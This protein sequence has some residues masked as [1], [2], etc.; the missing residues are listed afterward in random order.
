MVSGH[1][2]KS[3]LNSIHHVVQNTMNLHSKE[4]ILFSLRDFF[5]Q[6]TFY[7]YVVDSYGY[8]KVVDVTDLPLDAGINDD[9]TTRLCIQ[10]SF[11]MESSFYPALVVR[12]GSFNSVPISFN[13]E[14]SGVQWDDMIFE[15][16]YG[17]IS[18]FKTPVHFI[19]AGAWE[20]SINIDI[21]ARDMRSRDDLTDLVAVRFVDIAFN[22][23]V[24]EG[25]IVLNVSTSGP[26]ESDDRNHKVFK[27]TVTLKIRTEWRRHIPIS[28]IIEV[29]NMA[30]EFGVVPDGITAPNLTLNSE[31]TLIE[32]LSNL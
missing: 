26:T 11:K 19:F 16:G 13:R 10:E 20:G 12:A 2:Y 18:T 8:A 21:L 15:D 31:L 5:A 23:L 7:R 28:N 4:L 3:D 32:V 1:F 24:K 30:T 6:D 29:I 22:E 17:N 27:D 9:T 25:L 14:T